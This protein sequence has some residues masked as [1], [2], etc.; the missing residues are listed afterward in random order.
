MRFI[1]TAPPAS[2]APG[3]GPAHLVFV[4]QRVGF[5]ATTGGAYSEKTVGDIPPSTSGLIER[6]LDGGASWQVVLS[7]PHVVFEQVVFA[8]ALHGV[9]LGNVVH[10]GCCEA[11][12]PDLVGYVTDD[13]GMHWRRLP[14]L[15]AALAALRLA[16]ADAWYSTGSRLLFSDD[17][18]RTWTARALPARAVRLTRDARGESAVTAF[19]TASVGYAAGAARCGERLFKTTNGARSWTPLAGTCTS[20]YSSIDFLDEQ[21]GWAATGFSPY[22]SVGEARATGRLLIRFT[23][24]GGAS[25]STVYR[26]PHETVAAQNGSW[27]I[28]TQLHFT[29]PQHGWA[30]STET[31]QGFEH[32]S[33]HRT[34]DGGRVWRAVDYPSCTSPLCDE[35]GSLPSTFTGPGTAWAGEAGGGLLEHTSDGGRSWQLQAKPQYLGPITLRLASP[36]TLVIDSR[37]GALR[38]NDQ[39][40]T[41]VPTPAPS[42]RAVAQTAHEPAYIRLLGAAASYRNTPTFREMLVEL[43]TDGGRTWRA[44]EVP[45]ADHGRGE[46]SFI[47]AAH[48]LLSSGK[49]TEGEEAHGSTPVFATH[50]AGATW[51]QVR[52][53]KGHGGETTVM[54]GPGVVLIDEPPL[55]YLSTDEGQHWATTPFEDNYSE[56]SVSRPQR[57]DIWVL[58]SLTFAPQRLHKGAV[59]LLRSDDGGSTWQKLTGPVSLYGRRIVALSPREAWAGGQELWHTTDGGDAW[60]EV[61]PST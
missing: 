43:S 22:A 17:E 8:D 19:P 38:S 20:S 6:T 2:T 56:C 31:D 24:D 11:Q 28:D 14:R 5:L 39:G 25:W 35:G 60:Q 57:Q 12:P 13:G 34:V 18:G 16:A 45:P 47:D 61:W 33:V 9:A 30:V 41:W 55:L 3:L 58:C 53:P 4:S 27:P 10:G 32:D 26:G 40:R 50:N 42:Q 23:D 52:V 7:V 21:T 46:V 29:D 51:K 49:Q 59:M 36:G 48:G 37:A 44:L 54:L 1:A 15:P